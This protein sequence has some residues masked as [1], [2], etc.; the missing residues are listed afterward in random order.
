M[1]SETIR[2]ARV[3]LAGGWHEP[4]SCDVQGRKCHADDEGITRFCVDDA[5][6]VAAG[7]AEAAVELELEV[8]RQ[9]CATG[10]ADSLTTWLQAPGRELSEVLHLLA[11]VERRLSLEERRHV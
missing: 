10:S 1:P 9:L 6:R 2:R 3:L 4:F 7:S 5:L 8:Q 11:V